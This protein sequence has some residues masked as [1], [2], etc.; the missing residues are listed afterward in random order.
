MGRQKRLNLLSKASYSKF[1]KKKKM[2]HCQLSIKFKHAV[3]NETIY[4]T[5]VL[6]SNLCDYSNTYILVRGN[7]TIIEHQATKV[8]FKNC[9]PFTKCTTKID[10]TTTDDVNDLHL[11]MPVYNL[12]EWS[13]SD[14]ETTRSSRFYS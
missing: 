14:S 11:V 2:E 5:K 9:A 3:G 12:V 10:G 6:K 13:S 8:A 7:V 1:I 4:N